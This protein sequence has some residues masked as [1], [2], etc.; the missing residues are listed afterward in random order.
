MEYLR[1]CVE[2]S[3]MLLDA[4]KLIVHDTVEWAGDKF[5]GYLARKTDLGD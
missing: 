3:G 1:S 2:V 5:D 4:A